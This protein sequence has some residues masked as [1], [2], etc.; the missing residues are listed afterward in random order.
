[1]HGNFRAAICENKV[2]TLHTH[3]I[4]LKYTLPLPCRAEIGLNIT[5][6]AGSD[7][8]CLNCLCAIVF[9]GCTPLIRV[10]STV[11]STDK[12]KCQKEMTKGNVSNINRILFIFRHFFN[13]HALHAIFS[14]LKD[15]ES[16]S[17]ISK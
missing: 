15:I 13:L 14:N 3:I 11:L 10:L 6:T 16:L 1:M 4:P 2:Y 9:Q 17:H 12:R 7:N 5:H 8:F